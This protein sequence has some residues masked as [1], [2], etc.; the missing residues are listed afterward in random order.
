MDLISA[1]PGDGP[2]SRPPTSVSQ[3]S[4]GS[5][6]VHRNSQAL[7][8]QVERPGSGLQQFRPLAKSRRHQ[9]PGLRRTPYL[10]VY[11]LRCDDSETYKT[12]SRQ[13]IRDWIRANTPPS[14]ESGKK[15]TAQENHDASEWLILHVVLPN[16]SAAA[17]PRFSGSISNSTGAAK[18]RSNKTKWPGGKSNTVFEKIRSDFNSSSSHGIDRVAQ[19]RVQ[20]EDFPPERQFANPVVSIPA[21]QETPAERNNAWTDLIAKFK[22]L[23]LESFDHRVDQY[24]E[25]IR[26]RDA[27]RCLPGWNF[28]TFFVL[29]EGLARSFEGVGLV[30]DA[31]VIYDE[32][33]LGLDTA[34]QDKAD[35][36]N[37]TS[38]TTF[39]DFT[40]DI[41]R[42]LR[43]VVESDELPLD[44]QKLMKKP[45][46]E[47]NK[48]YRD[49]ILQN[50]I[51]VFDFRCY[52]FARQL[53]L[54]LRLGKATVEQSRNVRRSQDAQRTSIEVTREPEQP[55]DSLGEEDLSALADICNRALR[56]VTT[57]SRILR[58][59]LGHKSAEGESGAVQNFV[60]SWSTAVAEQILHDTASSALKITGDKFGS[61][62]PPKL[63]RT[64]S[65]NAEPGSGSA[66]RPARSSSL[67][68]RPKSVVDS[69]Y[70]QSNGE[71]ALDRSNLALADRTRPSD[72]ARYGM[73]ELANHRAELYLLQ[74]RLVEALGKTLH[75]SSGWSEVVHKLN[76]QY[77]RLV[78]K[79]E[80][81]SVQQNGSSSGD[82]NE[83]SATLFLGL[84]IP[85]LIEAVTSEESFRRALE[86]LN[87][88]ALA[89]YLAAN[90][91]RS[92]E[93]IYAD[94]AVIKYQSGDYASAVKYFERITPAFSSTKWNQIE[95]GMLRM[96]AE[97]LRA[98]H[99]KDEY[100]RVLL[101]ILQKTAA[102]AKLLSQRSGHQA[103]NT[104][105]PHRHQSNASWLDDSAVQVRGVLDELITYSQELP[106]DISV[107]MT[108][109]FS[110]VSVDTFINHYAER[111]GLNLR[112]HFRHLINEGFTANAVQLKLV[113][114][115]EEQKRDLLLDSD[116]SIDIVRGL[117]NC[118]VHSKVCLLSFKIILLLSDTTR[119]QHMGRFS[120][121]SLQ[122]GQIR[123]SFYMSHLQRKKQLYHLP[124]HR[125]PTAILASICT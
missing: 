2:S 38:A 92:A 106:Y 120:W 117:N 100:V 39:L 62:N 53:S 73:T 55:P 32:L 91:T 49:M 102:Q 26:E 27:Q 78:A 28:C 11:L 80:H 77:A 65:T 67:S 44:V 88:E 46:D 30:E 122:S 110:D 51:S 57:V 82:E 36:A 47:Y 69:P 118:L 24:E 61:A 124:Q 20:T 81:D 42:T 6:S 34:I 97:C 41:L 115:T 4:I 21:W 98:L 104:T 16:T 7:D 89:H 45:I 48:P 10:K 18:D 22:F 79:D 121:R 109:Y 25:D 50:K 87:T 70:G 54:L 111:D 29:K 105:V 12:V 13:L 96:Q 74:R 112:V 5:Q 40:D 66:D 19:V 99:R 84:C 116:G 52:I 23:I 9:I 123:S 43:R 68:F 8:G 71:I 76:E 33:S 103:Q 94:L 113:G 35:K 3:D 119:S 114:T 59:D 1:Q 85:K 58:D 108:T 75:W 64:R 93:T 90:Q 56:F 14:K 86:V 31:L 60:S 101:V 125:Q 63:S 95:V 15:A 17:Q 37:D 83:D 72:A 107:P